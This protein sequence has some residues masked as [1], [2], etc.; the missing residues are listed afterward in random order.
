MLINADVNSISFRLIFIKKKNMYRIKKNKSLDYLIVLI[1]FVFTSIWIRN[2]FLKKYT[3]ICKIIY[4][5][6]FLLV[7]IVIQ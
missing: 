6:Y 7:T 1:T 3:Y 4:A 5:V 2:L